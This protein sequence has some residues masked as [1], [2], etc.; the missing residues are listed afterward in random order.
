MFIFIISAYL[1]GSWEADRPDLFSVVNPSLFQF[2]SGS[3]QVNQRVL[4]L[5]ELLYNT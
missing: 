4:V 5:S 3:F 2:S 1:A